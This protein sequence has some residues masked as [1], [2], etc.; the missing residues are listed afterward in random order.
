MRKFKIKQGLTVYRMTAYNCA[1]IF[2]GPGLCDFCAQQTLSGYYIA[3]LNCYYCSKCYQDWKKRAVFYE[4]DT[5][6]EQRRINE[7]DNAIKELNIP[8]EVEEV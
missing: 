4:E 8:C 5:A 2:H 6:F 1:Q 3:V 7:I